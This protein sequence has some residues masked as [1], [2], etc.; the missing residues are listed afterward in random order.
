MSLITGA[1]LALIFSVFIASA[2]ESVEAV[3]I[4]LAAGTARHMRSAL[5]GAFTAL[6]AL[7]VLVGLFGPALTSLPR[8]TIRFVIGL[9]LLLFGL[10]WLRK[11]ILRYGGVIALHDEAKIF[12]EEISLAKGAKTKSYLVVRDWFAFTMSFKGVFLE[13][14]EVAFIVISFASARSDKNPDALTQAATAALLAAAAAGLAGLI[15]HKPLTRV[16]ENLMKFIVGVIAASFGIF[17]S[18]EGLG[19][20]WPNSE[21]DLIFIIVFVIVV[22]A[23][24]IKLV[25]ERKPVRAKSSK[26]DKHR[27]P[28]LAFTHFLYTFIVGDDWRMAAVV[29]SGIALG[30]VAGQ[31]ILLLAI[32]FPLSIFIG[33][34]KPR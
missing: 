2:V 30:A 16:P 11:A 20:A 15:I 23:V 6:L 19:I 7:A 17:W 10:Q 31:A 21:Y 24:A 29:V 33:T 22:S 18:I 12:N 26:D 5:Q 8:D 13:G 4:V 3:T 25:R 32:A 9:F 1:D 14:I 27:G 28:L 34:L